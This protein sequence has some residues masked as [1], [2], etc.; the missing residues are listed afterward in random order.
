MQNF[1]Y[2][3]LMLFL[4]LNVFL[5]FTVP[6]KNITFSL[7][8]STCVKVD[9]FDFPSVNKL[10]KQSGLA[11]LFKTIEGEPILSKSCWFQHREYLKAML[12]H[13]QYGHMPPRPDKVELQLEKMDELFEG[14]GMRYNGRL[15]FIA[16]GKEIHV[17]VGLVRPV[18]KGPF[19]LIVKNS[20]YLFDYS[21]ITNSQRVSKYQKQK[22][23]EIEEAV[24]KE[25]VKR[26]YAVAKFLRQDFVPDRHD[27]R[28][29]GVL[30]LYRDYDWGSIAA[31]AW[32]TSVVFDAFLQNTDWVDPKKLI[33]TGHSRGGKTAL[34]AGIFDERI[35]LT[36]PNSSGGGGTASVRFFEPGHTEQRLAHHAKRFPHWWTPNY[37]KFAEHEDKLPFDA[38]TAKALIAPRALL[39]THATEDYWANPYG[40]KVTSLAAQEVF[41]WLGI[42]ER[43]ALHWRV[44]GHQQKLE[45]WLILLD[46]AD[47]LF[48]GKPRHGDYAPKIDDRHQNHFN[49]SYPK[50]E[51]N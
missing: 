47:W 24:Y 1:R 5:Q 23:L 46:F 35:A 31:W 27:A 6:V 21:P 49:W 34:C 36:V 15:K 25:A 4:G 43:E 38:H 26:G 29:H 33:V 9:D 2:K 42:P 13:Y 32:G 20:N 30:K 40:T 39:N 51:G 8:D 3:L 50:H 17:R 16:R 44:G 19:P 14:E 18:G 11:D 45:D 7:N 28:K 10:P 12:A 22:R 37:Y 48:F 41:K